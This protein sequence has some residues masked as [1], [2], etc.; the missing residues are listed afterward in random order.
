MKNRKILLI[1][2]ALSVFVAIVLAC[3][4]P[5]YKYAILN[6][7]DRDFYQVLRIYDASKNQPEYDLALNKVLEEK[8][9]LTNIGIVPINI[10]N[11]VA[12][13]YGDDFAKF[14]KDSSADLQPPFYIV[15]NPKKNILYKGDLIPENLESMMMSP[16]RTEL[17][18]KLSKGVINLI[19]VQTRDEQ[20]NKEAEELLKKSIAKVIDLDLEIRSRENP[21]QIIDKKLLKPI[22]VSYTTVS[23]EDKQETWF[24]KQMIGLNSKVVKNEHPKVF[25]VVGRGFVFDQP[26]DGEYLNE[27][28]LFALIFF[29]SGPCSCTVKA[30]NSGTDIITTWDWD[31]KINVKLEPGEEDTSAESVA[32]F[33]GE[34]LDSPSKTASSQASKATSP[35]KTNIANE[36]KTA[37]KSEAPASETDFL[38][39][40]F[41][42][43][44]G[45]AILLIVVTKLMKAEK[46]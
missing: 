14:I 20:K 28:E 18:E 43:I 24:Y 41:F 4:T 26:L 37:L 3:N 10:S 25:G 38:K 45:I 27:D 6:W 12:G 2:L 15:I 23:P 7:A 16:K 35:Q 17:A 21:D 19:L 30:E 31:K 44:G 34:E 36:T 1:T 46:E 40:I 29:L 8:G 22:Q 11:D 9:H 39:I 32:G 33:G 5:V 42:A 13:L